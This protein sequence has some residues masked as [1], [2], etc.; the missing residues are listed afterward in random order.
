MDDHGINSAALNGS[1]VRMIA[2]AALMAVLTSVT[3]LPTCTQYAG[4]QSTVV[5]ALSATAVR[6][7]MAQAA[8]TVQ[9]DGKAEWVI[10]TGAA[11]AISGTSSLR[12]QYT[13]VLSA[14]TLAVSAAGTIIRPGAA[15]AVSLFGLTAAPSVTVGYASNINVTSSG[16]A[17]AS[18][19]LS[20]QSAWQRDGYSTITVNSSI[21][22]NGLR[23]AMA[24]AAP[25]VTST[26]GAN[27]VLT[28]G[29]AASIEVKFTTLA[30][31]STDFAICNIVSTMTAAPTVTQFG[32]ANVVGKFDVTATATNTQQ[33][34]TDVAQIN[35]SVTAAPRLALLGAA[36][37]NA[38]SAMQADARL[39]ILA[40]APISCTGSLQ[41][42]GVTF[43]PGSALFA[44]SSDMTARYQILKFGEAAIAVHSALFAD[45]IT[46][47]TVPAPAERTAYVAADDRSMAVMGESRLMEVT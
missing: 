5:S 3:A 34:A 17:D 12:A 44:V 43:R 26:A 18:V 37:V 32:G 4:A 35:L 9:S 28:Q 29:G 27:A 42:A 11:A 47:P 16:F 19:K 20:G 46:N 21:A 24:A 23:T 6:L 41:A 2:G 38:S 33:G 8:I 39:G 40:T 14:S 13:D 7:A 15:T 1:A 22:G 30:V 31:G 45:P 10:A 25:T 36:A